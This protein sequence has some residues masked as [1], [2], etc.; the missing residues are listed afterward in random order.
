MIRS[1][2][3]MKNPT[4]LTSGILASLICLSS[5][6]GTS[7]AYAKKKKAPVEKEYTAEEMKLQKCYKDYLGLYSKN[8]KKKMDL[9]KRKCVAISFRTEWKGIAETKQIDPFLRIPTEAINPK[10]KSNVEIESI[11]LK[12]NTAQIV[13][14]KVDPK[15]KKPKVKKAKKSKE[16]V[17]NPVKE[18]LCLKVKFEGTEDQVKVVSVRTCAG[19]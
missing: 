9:L 2:E 14:G 11:S 15:K 4:A 6:L 8:N 12:K 17:K 1:I 3:G 7:Q 18:T 19:K 5:V 16:A 13:F 10:W